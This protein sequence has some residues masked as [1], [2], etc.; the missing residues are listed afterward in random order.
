MFSGLGEMFNL[1]FAVISLERKTFIRRRPSFE[2]IDCLLPCSRRSVKV[3]NF[4]L[5]PVA[6]AFERGGSGGLTAMTGN[7]V[8]I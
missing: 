6:T 4:G 1:I 2:L 7:S 3:A 5:C 8:Q